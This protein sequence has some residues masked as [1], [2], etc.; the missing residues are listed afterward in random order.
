MDAVIFTPVYATDTYRTFSAQVVSGDFSGKA[1]FCLSCANLR[2]FIGN[3]QALH[4]TLSGECS[5][6]DYDSDDYLVFSA[7]SLGHIH[8]FGQ[9]G[10]SYND[11][12]LK[13]SCFLDQTHLPPMI[14]ALQRTQDM[15]EGVAYAIG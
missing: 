13:F 9:L 2:A 11:Q 15:T 4:S 8:V 10:G 12:F 14:T 6:Q 7:Q 5:L 3:L 1:N